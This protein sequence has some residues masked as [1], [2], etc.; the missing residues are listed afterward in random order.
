MKD[1]A[2]IGID[3]GG[4]QLRLGKVRGGTLERL[5]SQPVS[6]RAAEKVVLEE[7]YQAIDQFLDDEVVAIGCGVPSVVDVDSGTVYAVEN[8]PAWRETPLGGLLEKRYGLPVLVNNDANVFAL[9]EA[10]FGKGRGIANL[11]GMTL[12]TGLGT[13]VIIEGRLYCGSSC[14][15]GEIGSI[16]HRQQTVEAYCSGQFFLQRCGRT[17]AE[18]FAAASGGDPSALALFEDF[19]YELG[20]A[21]MT[22]LYAYDPEM[23]VL[24]GS[25]SK[26]YRYFERGLKRR[27]EDYEYQHSLQRTTITCSEIEHVAILG[28]AALHL[29]DGNRTRPRT[30]RSGN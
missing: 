15:A 12:G 20:H 28:A 24:G 1:E 11:V 13:G 5:H 14:G 8:I 4:T 22:V 10:Y 19:G 23:I 25:V 27:L 16:P 3:L 21:V 30:A 6:S 17:G 18:V 7:I 2:R 9:G 26:G 29:E